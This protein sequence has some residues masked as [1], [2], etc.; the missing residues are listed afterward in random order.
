MPG[1]L[2]DDDATGDSEVQLN[3]Y[4]WLEVYAEYLGDLEPESG[5]THLDPVLIG[6]LHQEYEEEDNNQ[7]YSCKYSTF[8]KVFKKK[9]KGVKI[10]RKKETSSDCWRCNAIDDTMSKTKRTERAPVKEERK[11]HRRHYRG[12]KETYKSIVMRTLANLLMFLSMIFDGMDQ[13]KTYVPWMPGASNTLPGFRWSTLLANHDGKQLMLGC[14]LKQKVTGIYVH[15][16]V[17]CFYI[18]YA[19]TSGDADL[20]CTALQHTLWL[21][22]DKLMGAGRGF[23]PYWY[24]Q[25]CSNHSHTH[26]TTHSSWQVDG[27]EWDKYIFA[28]FAWLVQI[29]VCM[30][31]VISRLPVGHTH[32]DIDQKFSVISIFLRG[33]GNKGIGVMH[34]CCCL[35]LGMV[36]C[37]AVRCGAVRCAAVRWR[38]VPARQRAV[39]AVPAFEE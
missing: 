17:L 28:Y 12:Q 15:G 1:C 26:T 32:S 23:S 4:A 19:W 7:F 16:L 39:R 14:R 31:V 3:V 13:W 38:C 24:I 25:V 18:T 9:L 22:S 21:I 27:G 34:I 35:P 33:K 20:N 36:R 8:C 5:Q 10:R 11:N 30:E 6:E 37:G 29:G 2:D